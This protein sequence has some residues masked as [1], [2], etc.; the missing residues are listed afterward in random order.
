MRAGWR[1]RWSFGSGEARQRGWRTLAGGGG[2]WLKTSVSLVKRVSRPSARTGT[3]GAGASAKCANLPLRWQLASYLL[4]YDAHSPEERMEAREETTR[5][6]T[7][8]RG[9]NICS[10]S[11]GGCSRERNS[12]IWCGVARPTSTNGQSTCTS[13]GCVESYRGEESGIRSA[14]CA[15]P[16]TSS[17]I[18]RAEATDVH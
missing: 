2:A 8:D 18:A 5:T 15:P 4:Q 7:G 12:S 14:L 9:S 10:K 16:A 6:C 11:R 13:G 17:T 1:A 3:G